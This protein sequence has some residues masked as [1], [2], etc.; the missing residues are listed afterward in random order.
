MADNITSGYDVNLIERATIIHYH[1]HRIDRFGLGH[2]QA[3]GW[4]D[5]ASQRRR[6]E[7]IAGAF[8]FDR[9]S[10]LDLGCGCGDLQAFL[11]GRFR[12]LDYLGID[13]VPEF[14]ERARERCAGDPR[15]QFHLGNFSRG[16]LPRVD[17]VVASGALG[18]RCAELD[19]HLRM[20][21]RMEA[22]ATRAVLF[23]VLDAATFPDHPLLIGHDVEA[24]TAFCRTLSP[25]V[26]AV[27]GY[28]PDDVTVVMRLDGGPQ[29]HR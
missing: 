1:R 10:V 23:N 16:E 22:T 14:I 7:A 6:F 20:I 12:D 18:Y 27:R 8:D 11:A 3:L 9:C 2:V 15:A 28:L 24:V 17:V 19:F 4:R 13:H 29:V 5:E 25:G 26:D 21:E